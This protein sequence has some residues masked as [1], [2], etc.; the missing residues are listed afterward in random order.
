MRDGKEV[1]QADS[2]DPQR[3]RNGSCIVVVREDGRTPLNCG[4]A[5]SRTGVKN[6]EEN[7]R[8]GT[9]LLP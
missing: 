6:L 5:A 4:V 1:A 2:I 3:N 8:F 7:Y 9:G